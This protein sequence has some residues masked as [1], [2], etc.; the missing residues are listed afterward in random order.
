MKQPAL[1]TEFDP[2]AWH[3]MADA[4]TVYSREDVQFTFMG[5]IAF[6]F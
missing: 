4:V 1:V 6:R 2:V 3:T 5:G